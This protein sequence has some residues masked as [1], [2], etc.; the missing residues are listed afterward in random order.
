MSQNFQK[1][2]LQTKNGTN[3]KNEIFHLEK[4][5]ILN[6]HEVKVGIEANSARSKLL[7]MSKSLES[8]FVFTPRGTIWSGESDRNTRALHLR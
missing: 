8:D 3:E 5:L 2:F 7:V 1:I 4:G 6:S